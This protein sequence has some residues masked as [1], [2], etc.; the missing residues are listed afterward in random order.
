MW[1]LRQLYI[2][3]S[4]S[5]LPPKTLILTYYQFQ[6]CILEKEKE[7]VI[8]NPFELF[9]NIKVTFFSR[10]T[11]PQLEITSCILIRVYYIY[12]SET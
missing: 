12:Q 2:K 6:F 8:Y 9:Y 5:F 3:A 1:E 7:A 10:K 4:K 11:S